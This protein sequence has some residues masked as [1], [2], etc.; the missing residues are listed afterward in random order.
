MG[1]DGVVIWN[2]DG[3]SIPTQNLIFRQY[4]LPL[5]TQK[6]AFAQDFSSFFVNFFDG[7]ILCFYMGSRNTF[8]MAKYEEKSC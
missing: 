2:S 7:I 4:V 1:G 5:I 3:L 6:I 8:H